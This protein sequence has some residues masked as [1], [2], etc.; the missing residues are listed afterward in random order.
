[1]TACV[2]SFAIPPERLDHDASKYLQPEIGNT[3]PLES[4]DVQLNDLKPELQD[5]TRAAPV[6]KQLEQRGFAV[7]K[8]KSKAGSLETQSQWNAEYLEDTAQYEVQPFI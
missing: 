3:W 7:L 8:N 4:H 5:P 6:M 1:M 2:L